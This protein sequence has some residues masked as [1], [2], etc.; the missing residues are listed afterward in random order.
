M[1]NKPLHYDGSIQNSENKESDAN[2]ETFV[3]TDEVRK[4]L[5]GNPFMNN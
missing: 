5:S 2:N 4:N 1:E 3:L